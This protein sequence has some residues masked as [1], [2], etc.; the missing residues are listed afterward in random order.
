M[1]NRLCYLGKQEVHENELHEPIKKITYS[2]NEIYCNRKSVRSSEFYQAQTISLRPEIVL[3]V[4]SI[5]YMEFTDDDESIQTYVLFN[6]REYSVIRTYISSE[7]K[8]ELVLQ[9]G[10][11]NGGT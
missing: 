5:D 7:D 2:T 1:W 4:R 3:E 11:V 10:I 8:M 9:R 6:D